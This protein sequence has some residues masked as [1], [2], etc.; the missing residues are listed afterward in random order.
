MYDVLIGFINK[1]I[2]IIFKKMMNYSTSFKPRNK[3]S[4]DI[5]TQ[6]LTSHPIDS[7]RRSTANCHP[8][9]KVELLRS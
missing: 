3:N 6:Y 2:S 9:P 5:P 1:V 7:N 4:A 8:L